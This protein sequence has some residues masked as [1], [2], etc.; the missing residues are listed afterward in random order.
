MTRLRAVR[1]A[2][3][4]SAGAA[5][6]LFVLLAWAVASGAAEPWDTSLR[7]LVHNGASDAMTA[8]AFALSFVGSTPV[9]VIVAVAAAGIFV[10]LGWSKATADL[11]IVMIGAV[12]L[13]NALKFAFARARPE[14]YF[15]ALPPTYSFPSGHATYAACLYGALACLIADRIASVWK[16]AVLWMAAVLLA[17][18]IGL[19]RIYL[20][21][22][23]PSDV[24]GGYLV[25]IFWI[26]LVTAFRASD[27]R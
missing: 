20:G 7:G 16:G 15:G 17:C 22:H 19:S 23:Y 1:L 8:A 26:G 4:S 27:R 12:V 11:A 9:W 6:V 21:V 2:G 24:A 18:A 25:A 13:E 5:A 10:R 14:V 3:A